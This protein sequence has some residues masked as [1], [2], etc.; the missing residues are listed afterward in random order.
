MVRR[1]NNPNR[2]LVKGQ[3]RTIPVTKELLELYDEYLIKEYPVNDSEYV[4]V[5]IWSGNIGA[6]ISLNTP[7]KIL[8]RLEKKTGIK[9]Y[10]HL[11]RHSYAT[12]LLRA[13]YSPERVKYLMGH[14][15]IST[16]LDT[17]SHVINEAN[18]WSVIE[19]EAEA[20]E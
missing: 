6:P 2:A 19:R 11:F 4:F 10:P 18:L 20:E 7:N 5:N 13:N 14:Q 17:Y 8:K 9:A 1:E 16:T 12:R 15:G 3:Q